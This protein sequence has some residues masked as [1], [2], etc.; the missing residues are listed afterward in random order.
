[1][2]RFRVQSHG[3]DR[4]SLFGIFV[5]IGITLSIGTTGRGLSTGTGTES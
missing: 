4:K 2:D 5:A 1:M 3:N